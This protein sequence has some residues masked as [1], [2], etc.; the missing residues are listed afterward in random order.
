[1][2]VSNISNYRI[3]DITTANNRLS[4]EVADLKVKLQGKETVLNQMQR[5]RKSLDE[6]M[7]LLREQVYSYDN[8]FV[9]ERHSR[10][11]LAKENQK[12]QQQIKEK[13]EQF[14]RFNDN[15][16]TNKFTQDNLAIENNQLRQQIE[17]LNGDVFAL[18]GINNQFSMD[19]ERLGQ[20]LQEKDAQIQQFRE[21]IATEVEMK[22]RV[23]ADCCSLRNQ[24]QLK[25]AEIH[26]LNA[27]VNAQRYPLDQEIA[28]LR[29]RVHILEQ[30]IATKQQ[31][32]LQVCIV[33]G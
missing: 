31:E 16:T 12:L 21:Q 2:Q 1:M 26:Q 32:I 33:Y 9:A 29:E 6:D 17:K 14:R 19:I 23:N 13:E 28:R 22:E 11:E 15:F 10:E 27:E 18:Q 30:T 25:D 24:L 4:N 7:Q 20:S 5:E 3:N 8:D